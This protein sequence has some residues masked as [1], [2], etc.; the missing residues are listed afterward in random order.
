MCN[1]CKYHFTIHTIEELQEY[2][3]GRIGLE[4]SYILK[5]WLDRKYISNLLYL[6]FKEKEVADL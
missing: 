6:E 4:K 2:L 3:D 5:I 1:R